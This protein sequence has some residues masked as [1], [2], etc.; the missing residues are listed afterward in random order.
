M[1]DLGRRLRPD[2]RDLGQGRR[3]LQLEVAAPLDLV[4]QPHQER[5]R[6]RDA[7][8]DRLVLHDDGHG[9]G[10]GDPAE[11]LEDQVEVLRVVRG[12]QHDRGRAGVLGPAGVVQRH[13]GRAGRDPRDDGDPAAVAST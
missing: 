5:R 11:V 12:R 2:R 13:V 7:G 4:E 9:D 10:V 8:V 1:P 3:L 6:H